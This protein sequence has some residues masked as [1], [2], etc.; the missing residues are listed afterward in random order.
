MIKT[1]YSSI[2]ILV[3][4]SI[5]ITPNAYAQGIFADQLGVSGQCLL[6]HTSE[7]GGLDTVK[8]AAL[9]A[10]QNGGVI[11]GLQN[12]LKPPAKNTTPVLHP[13]DNQ[14][15]VQVGEVPLTIP[16]IVTDK[17]ADNFVMQLANAATPLSPKGYSFSNTYTVASR[18]LPAINFKWKP[19]A[20]QK[21]KNYLVTFQA[22]E[23][24][25]TGTI[26][27]SNKV[28]ANIFV[29][30]A[31]PVSPKNV[32]EQFIVDNAKWVA[33]KLTMTGRLVFKKSVTSATKATALKSLRL[34]IKSN[35]GVTVGLPAVLT[36]NATGAWTSSFALTT[37]QVPCLVKAEYEKL[38]AA[39]ATKTAPLTC[40][41]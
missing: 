23:T 20:A 28:S 31:R 38:N 40:K 18:N 36:P 10:W 14:W 33:G 37:T 13:I 30:A 12:F 1:H 19:T 16:L 9:K 5:A 34:N 3:S 32:V 25:A 17:E 4:T 21:N 6:C 26:Q 2:M 35:S 15:N 24:T 29:W 41:K 8:P 11:P 27:L 7:E 22:K 39:R